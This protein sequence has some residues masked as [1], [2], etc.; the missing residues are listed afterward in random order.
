MR[1]EVYLLKPLHEKI[2]IAAVAAAV[3]FGATSAIY[4]YKGL[5]RYFDISS[6]QK[7]RKTAD[8][9]L[10]N[11]YLYDYNQSQMDDLAMMGYIA[12]LDD[13]YSGYYSAEMMERY[14]EMLEGEYV[15]IGVV[16]TGDDASDRLIIL[17]VNEGS[18]AEEAGLKAGD[19]II[20]VDG[21]EYY[22][23]DMDSCVYAIKGGREGT[24]VNMT[25]QRDGERKDITVKRR[26]IVTE[27]VKSHMLDNGIGYIR[28]TEFDEDLE[29]EQKGTYN[30]FK[31]SVESLKKQ[32]MTKLVIDLRDNPGGILNSVCRVADYLLPEG[33]VTYTKTKSGKREEYTSDKNELNI[34]IAVIINKNSASAAEVLTGALRD[35]ERAVIVG[36]K[37]FGKGVVQE[38][39]EFRDGSALKLTVARYYTPKGEC[40][41][42]KGI[43]PDYEVA[44]PDDFEGEFGSEATRD[45][46]TQ[47]KKAVEILE[48]EK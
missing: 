20:S 42:E 8:E 28:I 45:F 5:Q 48:N 18:S 31:N 3:T 25:I 41:H 21:E 36:E 23:R 7:K 24:A 6:L 19:C 43:E 17:S 15:G 30:D 47:L 10:K 40:I 46:D 44:L 13:P 34:P 38:F 16:I 33:C 29:D 27:T 37:S 2:L 4:S 39:F 11:N 14:M 12:G 1:T 9:Y 35:Y 26:R 32:G 22:S